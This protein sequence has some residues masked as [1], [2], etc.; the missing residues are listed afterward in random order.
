MS[1][2]PTPNCP[3]RKPPKHP[4]DHAL[5]IA[6]VVGGMM[7]GALASSI[8]VIFALFWVI[9]NGGSFWIPGGILL[10]SMAICGLLGGLFGEP[11]FDWMRDVMGRL[12]SDA[13]DVDVHD[14]DTTI[15]HHDWS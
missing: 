11:F 13:G 8:V 3:W 1:Y 15:S 4:M 14:W 7:L 2:G 6:H 5:K 9:E 12:N 10:G